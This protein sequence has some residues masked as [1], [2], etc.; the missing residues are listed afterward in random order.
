MLQLAIVL[1]I[2]SRSWRI[3]CPKHSQMNAIL[4][5][6]D[7]NNLFPLRLNTNKYG[8]IGSGYDIDNTV[9]STNDI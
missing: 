7:L 1:V 6:N 8:E 2:V 5:Q 4:I 3:I 9:F